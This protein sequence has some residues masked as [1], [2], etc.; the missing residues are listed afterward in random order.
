MFDK[1][2]NQMLSRKEFKGL[3]DLLFENTGSRT[4]EANFTEMDRNLNKQ[5]S[6]GEFVQGVENAGYRGADFKPKE[7]LN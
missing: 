2:N 4:F 3:S 6:L 1:K 7:N 5:I